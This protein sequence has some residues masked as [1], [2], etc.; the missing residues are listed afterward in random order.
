MDLFSVQSTRLTVKSVLQPTDEREEPKTEGKW[1]T[2]GC[3]KEQSLLR[4]CG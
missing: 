1:D 2:Q 4:Y 3:L